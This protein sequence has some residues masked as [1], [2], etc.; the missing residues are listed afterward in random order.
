MPRDEWLVFALCFGL[1]AAGIAIAVLVT[2]G[3]F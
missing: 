1:G 2:F 3:G